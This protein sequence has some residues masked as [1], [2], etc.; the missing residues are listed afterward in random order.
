MNALGKMFLK[1]CPSSYCGKKQYLK[2]TKKDDLSD[3]L[4]GTY[5]SAL[6]GG[7]PVTTEC[8]GLLLIPIPNSDVDTYTCLAKL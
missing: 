5:R 3:P 1:C 7:L 6:V 8:N 4:E 2:E